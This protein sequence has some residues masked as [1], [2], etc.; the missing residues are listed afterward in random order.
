MKLPA[1]FLP[2][3]SS[4]S[5]IHRAGIRGSPL[6]KSAVL[7]VRGAALA[8]AV[9]GNGIGRAD[10]HSL[11]LPEWTYPGWSVEVRVEGQDVRF[12]QDGNTGDDT[13]GYQVILYTAPKQAVVSLY[14]N[15]AGTLPDGVEP[16][17]LTL[18]VH[19]QTGVTWTL[20]GGVATVM[21][22]LSTNREVATR[23]ILLHGR[24]VLQTT[25]PLWTPTASFSATLYIVRPLVVTAGG[26]SG[27]LLPIY[28]YS[29]EPYVQT[30]TVGPRWVD[31]RLEPLPSAEVKAEPVEGVESSSGWLTTDDIGRAMAEVWAPTSSEPDAAGLVHGRVRLKAT[32]DRAT[33]EQ[34]VDIRL[35]YALVAAANGATL[36]ARAGTLIQP[37][38]IVAG[39]LLKPGDVVQVGNEVVWSGAYL[40]VRFCNGQQLTL[41]ADTPSG[42]RA[43]VGQGSFDHRTS[44]LQVT[45]QNA[46]QDIRSDPRRYGRMLIYKALGNAVDGFLGVPDPLGWVATT[47][48]GAVENWLAD[49][50]ESAYQPRQLHGP[51]TSA[52]GLHAGNP[53][54]TDAPWVAGQVDFFSDGTARVYNRGGTL[55]VQGPAASAVLP[56]GAMSV[57]RLD[58]PGG[59]LSAVGLAPASGVAPLVNLNPAADVTDVPPRPDLE[60]RVTEFGGNTVLPGGLAAR[61]DGV[62]LQTPPREENRFL[63]TLPPGMALS[64]GPHQWDVELALVGGGIVRTSVTFQVTSNLPAPPGVRAAAGAQRVALRWDS[65]ALASARGGFRVYRTAPGGARQ[66]VSGAA[67]LREP[68][69]L[70][71]APVAGAVYDV[72]GLDAAGREGSASAGVSVAFPGQVAAVPRTVSVVPEIREDGSGIALAIED[73]TPGFTLW[74]IEAAPAAEGPFTD[75]LDGELTSRTPWP[76]PNPFDETRRWFRVTAVNADGVAGPPVVVGPLDLPQP[77][78]P[79]GGLTASPNPDGSVW[80][81]WNPWTARPLA[82]YRLERWAGNTWETA[83]EVGP[84]V[85]AWTDSTPGSG[86]LRQWRVRARLAAGGESP[87]SLAAALRLITAPADPGVVRFA[88]GAAGG[89]EGETVTLEVIREGGLD[90]PAFAT[91]SSGQWTGTATPEQDFTPGGGLLIFAPGESRKT[92]AIPLLTDALA[93]QPDEFFQVRLLNVEGGAALGEPAAVQVTISEGAKLSWEQ[94]WL[95]G[96]EGTTAEVTFNVILTRPSAQEVRVDFQFDAERSTA[97]PDADFTGPLSGTLVFAP[98]QTNRSFTV[99]IVNDSLKEGTAPENVVFRLLNP[100]GAAMDDTDPFRVFATLQIGDDDTRPGSVVFAERTLRLR[101]GESRTLTLR[102]EGGTDGPIEVFI[103]PASGTAAEDEDWTLEPRF[104][105]FEEGQTE[106]SVTFTARVDGRAEGAEVVVLNLHGGMGPGQGSSLLVTIADLDGAASGFTAW[107]EQAL[108]GEPLAARAPTADAEGDGVPNWVEFLW[109]TDPARPDRPALPQATLNEWGEWQLR[110]TVRE[111]AGAVV[112]AEFAEDALWSRPTFDAGTW[113]SN[114]DG[115]RTGTFRYFNF[116]GTSGFARIRAE[117]L[118]AP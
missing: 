46:V 11:E 78:P 111:D 60:V 57:A 9:L 105:R 80:L 50:G 95:Y 88:S 55:R 63:L 83:A 79:V 45:L 113:Q 102:R 39:D 65:A 89:L 75:L 85:T 116:G 41:Q 115:T 92:L 52:A 23:V 97:T 6:C 17:S 101:E 22:D 4:L 1:L 96:Q 81:R 99:T 112:W 118:T 84:A 66:L 40:T 30:N 91:W 106:A 108:A 67:P 53:A 51:G 98:G 71:P 24:A 72:V 47:P 103:F 5:L 21:V 76:I 36:V 59:V 3:R 104:P 42:L 68:N 15:F 107:A 33:A 62:L 114:G 8:M 31:Y 29:Q 74:R 18:E 19:E 73:A 32:K 28:A 61:V 93:E 90:L 37:S 70:D 12:V 26:A 82:G 94:I 58:A 16:V 2:S 44:V 77:L 13:S 56:R 110:V 117:W 10:T 100:Q 64:P 86:E 48:G 49:F 38:P 34:E 25:D 14:A 35:P 27:G 87:A 109:R 7:M 54:P 69:F 43:V 20:E